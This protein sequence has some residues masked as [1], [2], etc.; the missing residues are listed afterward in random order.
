MHHP[1]V[2]IRMAREANGLTQAELAERAGTTQ[3]AV[4]RI[5]HGGRSP[6][7]ETVQRF[8]GVMGNELRYEAPRRE[9]EFDRDELLLARRKSPD[10]RFVEAVAWNRVAARFADEGARKRRESA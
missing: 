9:H 6:S 1:G 8:L 4:S 7:F 2:I 5:E 10:Q 3:S